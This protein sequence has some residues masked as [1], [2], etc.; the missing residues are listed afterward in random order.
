[1]HRHDV[2]RLDSSRTWWV[3]SVV[4]PRRDWPGA[5]GCRRGARFLVSEDTLGTSRDDFAAFESEGR[6]LEW[7][8]RHRA[9][10]ARNL[11]GASVRPVRLDRWLLGLD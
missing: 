3:P 9:H 11:P 5:P 1:M 10:L 6:C 8:M 7:I 4:S 2:E